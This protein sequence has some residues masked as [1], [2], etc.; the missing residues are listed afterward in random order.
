MEEITLIRYR[1]GDGRVFENKEEAIAIEQKLF[2]ECVKDINGT[3]GLFK[4]LYHSRANCLIDYMI[5]Q[6]KCPV[7][8]SHSMGCTPL[9]YRSAYVW[10]L[11]TKEQANRATEAL[12]VHSVAPAHIMKRIIDQGVVGRYLG[13]TMVLQISTTPSMSPFNADAYRIVDG[14]DKA[15]LKLHDDTAAIQALLYSPRPQTQT[16]GDSEK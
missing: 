12:S 6:Y 9:F 2:E 5:E 10:Q 8:F 1:I 3:G 16:E 15:F 14:I 13:R 7:V 11:K 4:R